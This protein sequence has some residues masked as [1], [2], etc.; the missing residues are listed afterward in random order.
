VSADRIEE[1]DIAGDFDDGY[2]ECGA[3][4][5]IEESDSGVCDCCGLPIDP[6]ED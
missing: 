2:C 1:G 4:H 5:C 6:N 3:I